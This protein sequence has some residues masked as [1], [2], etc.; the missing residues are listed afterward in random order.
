MV[1]SKYRLLKFKGLKSMSF[2][3]LVNLI[4]SK[5]VSSPLYTLFNVCSSSLKTISS[6]AWI[7]K[8]AFHMP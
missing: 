7:Y 1:L 4:A 3:F 8:D 6:S 5:C 2:K